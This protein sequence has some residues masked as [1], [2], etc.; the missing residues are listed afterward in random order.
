MEDREKLDDAAKKIAEYMDDALSGCSTLKGKL[1][2]CAEKV[3]LLDEF[4]A[5]TYELVETQLQLLASYNLFF[6]TL[7]GVL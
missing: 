4:G 7:K 1:K 5:Q 6:D 3:S 2:S